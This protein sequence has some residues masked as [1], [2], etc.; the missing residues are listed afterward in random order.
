MGELVRT[1]INAD[2]REV[3]DAPAA[4]APHRID[5]GTRH[6]ERTRQ[7]YSH[8]TVPFGKRY[9][10]QRLTLKLG[11]QRRIIY[12]RVNAPK[13][14]VDIVNAGANAIFIANIDGDGVHASQWAQLSAESIQLVPLQVHC[15]DTPSIASKLRR[16]YAADAL[17]RTSYNY[18]TFHFPISHQFSP[19]GDFNV[20]MSRL[21][22]LMGILGAVCNRAM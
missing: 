4:R 12:Q 13:S 8:D 1:V 11:E 17:S 5:Y 15:C 10:Q 22:T 21:L 14:F 6:E 9:F 3:D 2:T 7:V 16:D 19:C 18:Y 20:D